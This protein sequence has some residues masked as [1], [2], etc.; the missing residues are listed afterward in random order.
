MRE[1]TVVEKQWLFSKD[2]LQNTPSVLGGTTPERELQK[3]KST[4]Y[5]VRGL[6]RIAGL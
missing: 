4:I 6:G 2:D 3:R 5:Q 1:L